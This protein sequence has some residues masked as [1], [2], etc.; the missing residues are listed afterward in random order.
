MERKEKKKKR[1]GDLVVMWA[2]RKKKKKN[3]RNGKQVASTG[4]VVAFF[5]FSSI[6][7]QRTEL[8]SR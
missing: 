8:L 1:R 3:K 4:Y 2:G 6:L 5:G 7:H